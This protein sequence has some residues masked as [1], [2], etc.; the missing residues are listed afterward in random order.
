MH[1]ILNVSPNPE[2]K[3]FTLRKTQAL[4]T[5]LWGTGLQEI[6]SDGGGKAQELWTLLPHL[7]RLKREKGGPLEVEIKNEQGLVE[8]VLPDTSVVRTTGLSYD[9][10]QGLGL[11]RQMARENLGEALAITQWVQ[12]FFGNG[13]MVGSILSYPDP[14][15]EATKREILDQFTGK[16]QGPHQSFKALVLDGGGKL[17]RGTADNKAAQTLELKTYAVQDVARWLNISPPFLMELSRATFTNITE[18]GAWHVKYSLGPWFVEFEQA[19]TTRLFT[20]AELA[21]GYCVKFMPDALLRGAP[22]ERAERHRIML[23]AGVTTINEVRA[24]EDL[25]PIGPEGDVHMVP[26]NTQPLEQAIKEPE[27]PPPTLPANV[28]EPAGANAPQDDKQNVEAI[29]LAMMP[30]F[31]DAATRVLRKE[32]AAVKRSMGRTYDKDKFSE[33]LDDFYIKHEVHIREAFVAPGNTMATCLG[34]DVAWSAAHIIDAYVDEHIQESQS[35][36]GGLDGWTIDRP[37]K[38]ARQI[39]DRIADAIVREEVQNETT[40]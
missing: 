11:V 27:K 4:H 32:Q 39:T 38:V 34:A 35:T 1:R 31:V 25:N 22:K 37:G 12:S 7:A 14:L 9:G 19:Y 23:A 24:L 15:D 8:R 6:V 36:L 29:K 18:L 10:I 26:V 21:K 13:T 16:Y 3:P 40:T 2:T 20:A 30:V 28:P 33:W 17:E 5:F